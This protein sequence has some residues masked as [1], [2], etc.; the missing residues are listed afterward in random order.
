MD[1]RVAMIAVMLAAA[2]VAAGEVKPLDPASD[3]PL[4]QQ[5]QKATGQPAPTTNPILR[6][7]AALAEAKAT[8][9]KEMDEKFA[10]VERE[11]ARL[12]ALGAAG[13]ARADALESALRGLRDRRADNAVVKDEKQE[14]HVVGV[15]EG[16]RPGDLDQVAAAAAV[17]AT[18]PTTQPQQ[19][20]RRREKLAGRGTAVVE[21]QA[22]G[23]PIVLVISAYEPVKWEVRVA[24]DADLRKVVVGGYYDQEVTGLAEGT[25]V[26]MH[27]HQGGSASFFYTYGQSSDGHREAL[28]KLRTLTGLEPSTVQGTYKYT[29]EP[30]VVGPGS[31]EWVRQRILADLD[32]LHRRSIAW[33]LAKRRE[34]VADRRFTAI[35]FGNDRMA[36]A[37]APA[38][39][40]FTPIGPI[41]ENQRP[42]PPR[43]T[44]VAT[45]PG[46]GTLYALTAQGVLRIDG[47]TGEQKTITPNDPEL[48]R[49]TRPAAL[50]FDSKR[51]RL[52]VTTPG[53]RDAV[54]YAYDVAAE[55]WSVLVDLEGIELNGLVYSP[56]DDCF[57]GVP[58]RM[59]RHKN[60]LIRYTP[61]GEA[62]QLIVLS[63]PTGSGDMGPPDGSTQLI[64][65]GDKLVLLPA[66]SVFAMA[67]RPGTTPPR[68]ECY[69]IDPRTGDVTYSGKLAPSVPAPG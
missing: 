3:E 9:V 49:M 61:D 8:R 26:E 66:L 35:K 59:M 47:K 57:Y 39:A 19:R 34:A 14:L 68:R 45:D 62:D 28:P 40:E 23:R 38:L 63:K 67:G 24:K 15:H 7:E 52:V 30:L 44:A 58:G 53:F 11:V 6:R 46:D 21:V 22:T 4:P 64:P 41:E 31:D 56:K 36:R 5:I 20:R 32:P 60:M 12:R 37:A 10:A 43:T 54:M 13:D 50:A 48:P 2:S 17:A 51:R 42:L 55:K 69:V 1:T 18:G 33:E 25:T 29:G 27:T 16:L 65:V